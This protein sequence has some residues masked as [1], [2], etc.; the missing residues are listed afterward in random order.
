MLFDDPWRYSVCESDLTERPVTVVLCGGAA[1]YHTVVE[2]TAEETARFFE[3]PDP[4]DDLATA[5]R[6]NSSAF[7]SRMVKQSDNE[8][9]TFVHH[10]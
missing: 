5:I 4:L 7:S 8:P 9:S 3:D 1:I 6:M 10:L 2:F